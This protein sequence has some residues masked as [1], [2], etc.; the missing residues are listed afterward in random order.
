MTCDAALT[1]VTTLVFPRPAVTQVLLDGLAV[2]LDDQLHG[3]VGV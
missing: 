3:A 2:A 1:T